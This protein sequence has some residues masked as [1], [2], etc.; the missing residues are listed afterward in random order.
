V[1]RRLLNL[2]TSFSLLLFA[3][4]A[5]LWVRSA[6]H[7]ERVDLRHNRWREPDHLRATFVGVSWYASTL[8]LEL[9][10][11]PYTRE[12]VGGPPERFDAIRSQHPRGFRWDF[13]GDNITAQMNGYPPGFAAGHYPYGPTGAARGERWVLAVHLWLPTLLAAVPPAALVARALRARAAA[14]RGVCPSCGYDLRAT[15]DQCPE[16]GTPAPGRSA[17]V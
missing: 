3:A 6:S 10:S 17:V 8:R 13:L 7:F 16:C 1:L 5:A 12:Q 9:I 15:P 4:F 14:R 2:L 11:T